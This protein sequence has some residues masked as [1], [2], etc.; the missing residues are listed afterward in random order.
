LLFG[1]QRTKV[2]HQTTGR[3]HHGSFAT[4]TVTRPVTFHPTPVD[5][6]RSRNVTV[7]NVGGSVGV[8]WKLQNFKMSFGY[9]ADFFFNAIDGGI[10][11]R[12]EENRGFFGPFA[13]IAIGLGG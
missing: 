8:S 12:K 2:Q 6:T 5:K 13:T 7:P 3:Y 1:R 9:K 10:D 11:V 4:H